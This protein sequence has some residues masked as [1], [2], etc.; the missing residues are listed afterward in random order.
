MKKPVFIVLLALSFGACSDPNNKAHDDR[1]DTTDTR[2]TPPPLPG[3]SG[4]T[5][6]GDTTMYQRESNKMNDS[7]AK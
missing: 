5:N 3:N 7:T 4:D 1:T 6:R 2:S